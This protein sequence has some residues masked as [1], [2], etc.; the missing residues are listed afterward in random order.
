[1]LAALEKLSRAGAVAESQERILFEEHGNHPT[2][3]DDL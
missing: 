2:K 1:L 3:E